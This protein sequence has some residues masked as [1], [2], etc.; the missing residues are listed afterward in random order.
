MGR[1]GRERTGDVEGIG[2]GPGGDATV[3]RYDERIEGA[4]RRQERRQGDRGRTG[5]GARGAEGR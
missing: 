1:E 2:R 3:R 5:G 4:L